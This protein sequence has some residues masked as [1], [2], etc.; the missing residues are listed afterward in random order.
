M[1][2]WIVYDENIVSAADAESAGTV[3]KL[4]PTDLAF[5]NSVSSGEADDLDLI[6]VLGR[7]QCDQC[8]S[9]EHGLIVWMA[10]KEED[11]LIAQLGWKRE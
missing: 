4:P 3:E 8:G 6:A 9:E 7:K 2:T 5:A 1:E 11:A 10:D